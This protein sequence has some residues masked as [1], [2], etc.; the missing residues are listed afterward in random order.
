MRPFSSQIGHRLKLY[1][2]VG[3]WVLDENGTR[4]ILPN[5]L[6]IFAGVQEAPSPAEKMGRDKSMNKYYSAVH[7]PIMLK[8]GR[9]MHYGYRQ[10]ES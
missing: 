1:L 5:S 2:R 9:L 8:F 7:C 4:D 3:S 6:L 10:P